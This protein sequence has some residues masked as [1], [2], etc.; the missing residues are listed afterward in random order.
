MTGTYMS[1]QERGA[2]DVA[3]SLNVRGEEILTLLDSGRT[4][5][6][7]LGLYVPGRGYY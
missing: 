5:G 1:T 2:G 4:F 6:K 3:R 7:Y